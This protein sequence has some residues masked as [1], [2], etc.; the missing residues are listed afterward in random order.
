MPSIRDGENTYVGIT[1]ISGPV[2]RLGSLVV[3]VPVHRAG[4]LGSN[5]GQARIFL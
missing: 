2:D 5:P 1:L 3:I 4:D